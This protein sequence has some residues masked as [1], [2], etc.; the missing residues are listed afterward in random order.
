[1]IDADCRLAEGSIGRLTG[2]CS[3]TRA[4]CSSPLSHDRARRI[5]NK[6]TNR[7]ICLAGKELGRGRSGL[8]SLGLPCQMVGTGM[9]LPRSV[10][11]TA[12]LASGWILED[13]KLGLDLGAAGHPPRYSAPLRAWP[14]VSPHRRG[15][16]IFSAAAGE[17]GHIM[18]IVKLAPRMLRIAIARANFS[19]LALAARPGSPAAVASGPAV[20]SDVCNYGCRCLAGFWLRRIDHKYS[21][22]CR[23]P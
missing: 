22:P 3:M 21:L 15:E 11:H 19:L 7:C 9:A 13:L 23:I 8:S 6:Q 17:H 20:N 1:M 4:A 12:D 10:I 5:A 16:P 18:T 14:G 2:A